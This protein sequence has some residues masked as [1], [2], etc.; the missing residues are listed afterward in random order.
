MGEND[1]S[2]DI[3]PGFQDGQTRFQLLLETLPHI[4]F[5]LQPGGQA[6][7]Y[8]QN[9]IRYLGFIPG[10]DRT[11]R[12]AL[13]HP[14]DRGRVEAARIAAASA[15][16]EYIVEIRLPR[17]DGAYRWH[18]IHN[19][20]LIRDGRVILWIGTAVDIHDIH[21]ANEALEQRVRQRTADLEVA[22][23]RLTAE[24]QQR[25][26]TEDVLRDSELRYRMMYNRTPMAL[27]SVDA[28]ARLIDVNDTWVAMFGYDRAHVIG[29]SPIEF[30]T[31]ESAERY[32]QKAWPEMLNSSEQTRTVDYQFLTR[33]GRLFDGRLAARGEFDAAGRFVRSWAAIADVTAEK[34][35]SK[36]LLQAQRME[37]IGQLTA[38]VAH[39]FNN[40]LTAVLGNLELL[41]KRLAGEKSRTVALVDGATR[42]AER[43][44][45][46][47]A[48]LLAFSRQQLISA[49]PTDI[50]CVVHDMLPLLQSTI[51]ATI[52]IDIGLD[53]QLGDALADST[54][55]ELAILNLAINARDAMPEGGAIRIAT[56]NASRT[57][58][59][60]PE[61]PAA[62]DYIAVSVSD[63]GAGMPP[64]IQERMFEPFFTTKGVGKGSGLGL[65]Q[66]LGVAKQLGGGV[67]V[68]ST[69]G[70]GTCIT[71]FLPRGTG[72][73]VPDRAEPAPIAAPPQAAFVLLVDDDVDVRT[74]AA[75]ILES[76][77]FRVLQAASGASALDLLSHADSPVEVMVVDVAMPGINGV[78]LA[79]IVRHKS[80]TLPIVFMTGYTDASLLPANTRDEVLRKPFG[81]GEL[82]A[83]VALAISRNADRSDTP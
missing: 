1:V 13:I 23:Q 18:R 60:R 34:R 41:S 58:P 31:P 72:A 6:E 77:G 29:R 21:Q 10:P 65:A 22:N 35:A 48:Q 49:E 4:A 63:T 74:V 38:G 81:P 40:L 14:D 57:E 53:A 19:K 46:L 69:P 55:L 28:N 8:N 39:D 44:A 16:T 45:K 2:K 56:T 52:H 80:P 5:V 61:E 43:G 37:A 67:S 27:Q 7:Y 76:A 12:D 66:V 15:S 62:G 68:S 9:F 73:R 50:N 36:E 3:Q 64:E 79:K 32:Q 25:R 26:H 33:A 42:A 54:Q 83:K 30:M 75:S 70:Q 82:E 20:P 78:E 11:A 59:V 47:T 51:G 71:I 24:I 17:H